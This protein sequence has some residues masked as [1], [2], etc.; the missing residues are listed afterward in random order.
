M[1]GSTS[2]SS[3]TGPGKH[4]ESYRQRR[5]GLGQKKKSSGAAAGGRVDSFRNGRT[6]AFGSGPVA[7]QTNP[8]A[9]TS[10]S[11][12]SVAPGG[13]DAFL[14][15]ADRVR[16]A[17]FLTSNIFEGKHDLLW[18]GERTVGPGDDCSVTRL[19]R[20][21]VAAVDAFQHVPSQPQCDE[22]RRYHRATVQILKKPCGVIRQFYWVGVIGARYRCIRRQ[23]TGTLG[24]QGYG[25]S[26]APTSGDGP[27]ADQ[28]YPWRSISSHLAPLASPE[29]A[30]VSTRNRKHSLAGIEA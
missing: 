30:A 8:I 21:A 2:A 24:R 26:P 14:H 22:C 11:T 16:R 25:W 18:S 29:R 23:V 20:E 7:A 19:A 15:A 5:R 1:S 28:R 13:E 4:I 3:S 10:L 12:A 6:V 27:D 9:T 17:P